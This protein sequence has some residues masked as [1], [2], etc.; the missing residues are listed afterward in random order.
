MNF[1]LRVDQVAE[2]RADDLVDD[3]LLG[4]LGHELAV[5]RHHVRRVLAG[6]HHVVDAHRLAVAILHGH[7]RLPVGTKEGEHLL[8]AHLG[9]L[10]GQPVREHDR[11][12]HQLRGLPARVTEHHS[13]IAGTDLPPVRDTP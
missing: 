4:F 10:H 7:L 11:Q 5:R 8:L 2:H 13:L 12:R 9:Q 1:V 6:E 3:L